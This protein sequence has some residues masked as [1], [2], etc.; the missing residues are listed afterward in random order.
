MVKNKDEAEQE[1]MYIEGLSLVKKT[2]ADYICA[3]RANS[4]RDCGVAYP[5]IDAA[6]TF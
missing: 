6:Q 2:L 1:S 3:A 5:D 4:E